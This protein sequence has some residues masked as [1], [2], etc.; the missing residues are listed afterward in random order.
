MFA[1][2]LI[3]K[4]WEVPDEFR[5]R[6]GERAGRQRT[7]FHEG[8]LLLVLHK[9][10][11]PDQDERQ[12]ALFWRA[13]SGHWS[14]TEQGS[15]LVGLNQFLS[16]YEAAIDRWETA[17]AA[18]SNAKAYFDVLE[19]VSP[20]QRA[21]AHVHTVLGEARRLVEEDRDLI[22]LRDRAYDLERRAD[23]LYAAAKNGLDFAVAKRAEE[24]AFAAQRAAIASH[25]LNLLAAFFFPIATL[26][27][28]FGVNLQFGFEDRPGPWPFL[29]V[30]GIGLILGVFL[31]SIVAPKRVPKP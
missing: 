29:I 4:I 6:L 16:D 1:K 2:V 7:M 25:R 22:N 12:A 15:G 10:P 30:M 20:V 19:H 21:I 13:P 24:Q 23:L 11:M 26:S 27:A 9:A 31:T 14:S 17:E 18:A 3:P 8:H 28:V 5:R